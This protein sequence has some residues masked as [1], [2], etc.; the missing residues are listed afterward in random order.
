MA[1]PPE[2]RPRDAAAVAMIPSRVDTPAWDA[3]WAEG[4]VMTL[5]Q[6]V[7]YALHDDS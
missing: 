4:Q 3:A 1:L 7:K 5:E 2:N 6:A